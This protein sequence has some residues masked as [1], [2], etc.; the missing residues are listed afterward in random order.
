MTT[1]ARA[2]SDEPRRSA[3]SRSRSHVVLLS[4][5]NR[6]GFHR[7]ELYF[8]E[9]GHHLAWGYVDQPPLTPLLGRL[10]Q[11]VFGSSPRALRVP[12]VLV[13]MIV[14]LLIASLAPAPRRH[15]EGTHPRR[16]VHAPSLPS[17]SR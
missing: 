6:Y 17:S 1:Y 5:A 3:A 12:S 2:R 14:V 9:A 10:S 15:A 13:G 16:G 4:T 7:D 8:I 11:A